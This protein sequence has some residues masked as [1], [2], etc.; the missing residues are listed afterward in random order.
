MYAS[1]HRLAKKETRFDLGVG[2]LL[3]L[4]VFAL[5]IQSLVPS[6]LDGDPGHFQTILPVLGIPYPTGFP[7][8]VLL[9]HLW[10]WLPIGSVAYRINLFS[11]FWGALTVGALFFTLRQQRLHWLASLCAFTLALVPPSGNTRH[12]LPSTPYTHFSPSGY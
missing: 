2:F 7:L 3:A 6:M 9:G 5:Y 4:G 11:A 12:S 10:S 1:F 8:Y